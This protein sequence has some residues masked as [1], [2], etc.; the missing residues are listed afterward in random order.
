MASLA[1]FV[2]QI[3]AASVPSKLVLPEPGTV[4]PLAA[5]HARIE[6]EIRAVNVGPIP[7]P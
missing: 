5:L 6:S 3:G 7:A 2:T 4:P 1:E